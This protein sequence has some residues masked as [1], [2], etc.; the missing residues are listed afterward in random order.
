[1]PFFYLSFYRLRDICGLI[2]PNIN[3]SVRNSENGH[4]AA[5]RKHIYHRWVAGDSLELEVI[6]F[7]GL[8]DYQ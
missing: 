5:N 1:M 2:I 3:V 6:A 8:G 4:M 7:I